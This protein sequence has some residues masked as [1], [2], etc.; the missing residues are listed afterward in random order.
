MNPA[1]P[2]NAQTM[3]L[4]NPVRRPVQ[5]LTCALLAIA[6]AAA[7]QTPVATFR[8]GTVTVADLEAQAFLDGS[9][10]LDEHLPDAIRIAA[11]GSDAHTSAARLIAFNR[12]VADKART[13]GLKPDESVSQRASFLKELMLYKTLYIEWIAPRI[14][15]ARKQWSA[16]LAAAHSAHKDE[17]N[18]PGEYCFRYIFIGTPDKAPDDF[19]PFEAKAKEVHRKI[20]DGADFE[21]TAGEA[22]NSEPAAERCNLVG[23]VSS[24]NM[25]PERERILEAL[26]VGGVSQPFR[27]NRGYMILKLERRTPKTL[28]SAEEASATLIAAGHIRRFLPGEVVDASHRELLDAHPVAYNE[29]AMSALTAD[30]ATVVAESDLFRLRNG[31]VFDSEFRMANP[32]AEPKDLRGAA[33]EKALRATCAAIATRDHLHKAPVYSHALK[34]LEESA[35]AATALVNAASLKDEGIPADCAKRPRPCMDEVLA[36]N[37]FEMRAAK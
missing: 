19:A 33:T 15:K 35:L 32:G 1:I 13:R 36:A 23:P 30:A 21:K 8:G 2:F 17:C 18:V 16:A 28:M 29:S 3:P 10:R 37:N 34:L 12:I 6:C 22:S 20:V 27:T 7:A 14:V 4:R 5:F 31:E 25:P 24:K 26:A 9:R 11:P